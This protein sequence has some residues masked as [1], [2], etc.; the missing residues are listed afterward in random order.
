MLI[1]GLAITSFVSRIITGRLTDVPKLNCVALLLIT[2]IGLG[3]CNACIPAADTFIALMCVV[4]LMGVFDGS[5]MGMQ[6]LMAFDLLGPELAGQG[7]SYL[8]GI[9]SI[10]SVV[11]PPLAGNIF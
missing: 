10:P 2:M 11:G 5:F 4:M 1:I 9:G 6:S 3:I 7:T 8:L